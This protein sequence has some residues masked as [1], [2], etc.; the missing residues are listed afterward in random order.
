VDQKTR[1]LIAQ[2]EL[3]WERFQQTLDLYEGVLA[4]TRTVSTEIER[5]I[6]RVLS[7]AQ[8]NRHNPN[9]RA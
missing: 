4:R 3:L 2:A 8:K 9:K 7:E 5:R 6:A 1:E